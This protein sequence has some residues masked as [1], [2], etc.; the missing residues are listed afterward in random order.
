M[1]FDN[2]PL[3]AIR[4]EQ[5]RIR[6]GFA[7]AKEACAFFGWN[8]T[9]YSQHERGERGIVRVADKYAKAFRASEAWLLTG[10]GEIDGSTPTLVQ[11]P[12]VSWVSAGSLQSS[13]QV[14]P[15]DDVPM[16]YAPSLNPNSDWIA[17]K[18]VGSSM[19]R[20]S[21]PDSII[22]VDLLDKA[23]VANACYVIA[24]DEDGDEATYKR[25][26]PDPDRWE[27]VTFDDSHQTL[28]PT[29]GNQPRI[30]GR[31]K[32]SMISLT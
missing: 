15:Y 7:T 2:R 22:F 18:V 9:S 19:D 10:E 12:L 29:P 31:V 16:V 3:A 11:A 24:A 25:F 20:I 23:L 27:P 17:L 26:R 6:R 5:A 4:L 14:M 32:L 1:A 21:P 28:F 13:D 30:I 8:Y